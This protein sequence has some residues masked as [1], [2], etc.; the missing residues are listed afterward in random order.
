MEFSSKLK[1]FVAKLKIRAKK[2]TPV[3]GRTLKKQ[4]WP[5]TIPFSIQVIFV[6]KWTNLDFFS[7]NW[8][9]VCHGCFQIALQL[10][11]LSRFLRDLSKP[12]G[13]FIEL[14]E[15]EWG[16]FQ[17]QFSLIKL[18]SKAYL[19]AYL[20]VPSPIGV[21]LPLDEVVSKAEGVRCHFRVHFGCVDFKHVQHCATPHASDLHSK[22]CS[23][24]THT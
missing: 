24:Y 22:I 23:G 11:Q 17:L 14:V 7:E 1:G 15:D 12:S 13:H 16:Q 20:S 19:V 6:L 10:H 2:F 5:R 3:V 9:G 18:I 21:H 4:A 8:H